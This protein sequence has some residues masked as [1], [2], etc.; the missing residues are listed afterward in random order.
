MDDFADYFPGR[1]V[2]SARAFETYSQ[3]VEDPRDRLRMRSESPQLR[4]DTPQVL[5]NGGDATCQG[6]SGCRDPRDGGDEAYH[7][8]H[9]FI[10]GAACVAT[11]VRR[12]AG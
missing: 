6:G 1:S 12:S 9:P 11:L 7:F 5:C 3:L 2:D 8:G 10:V 4:A